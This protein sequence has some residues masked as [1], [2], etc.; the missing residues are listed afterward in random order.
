MLVEAFEFDK[1]EYY[2][3]EGF[4]ELGIIV[5]DDRSGVVFT[6]R[7]EEYNAIFNAK[8]TLDTDVQFLQKQYPSHAGWIGFTV[9]LKLLRDT[10]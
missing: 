6:D 2:R 7:G 10:E 9:T 1:I 5:K 3:L 4:Y 8:S